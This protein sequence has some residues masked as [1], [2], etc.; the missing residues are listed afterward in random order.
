MFLNLG[1]FSRVFYKQKTY[2]Y[3]AQHIDKNR[4]YLFKL[5][6]S[7]NAVYKDFLGCYENRKCLTGDELQKL[8]LNYL[9]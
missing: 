5:L 4:S 7:T 6:Y 2:I 8:E 1:L 9:N 3:K